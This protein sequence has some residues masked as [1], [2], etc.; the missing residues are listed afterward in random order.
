[1]PH[2][3]PYQ[4]SKRQLAP[5]LLP[6]LPPAQRLFEPFAGSA[7]LSLAALAAGRVERVVLGDSY[8]PLTALWQAVLDDPERLASGYEALWQAQ[9]ANPA[10]HFAAVRQRFAQQAEPAALL[11]LLA[12]CVKN[13]PRWNAAGQFNQTAD[14]RRLGTRPDRQRSQLL[15]AH[16]LLH[17][18]CEVRCGDAAATSA[19][20]G[21]A[22]AVYL[23]PPW[24]G[25]TEGRDRR[26]HMGLA[27]MQLVAL[28]RSLQA[29]RVGWLLSYDGA[30]LDAAGTVL[31]RYG[32]P[33]PADLAAE[34][35]FVAAGRSSQATLSGRAAWTA[36]SLYRW[37]A[38]GGARQ[39][40]A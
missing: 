28:L 16:A 9:L 39:P 23:D 6:W 37:P 17:G 4:G 18:R 24:Q 33:L 11:Y 14:H 32:D 12:R 29:R 13:A 1:M 20:A 25:T 31:R 22:D 21:P 26:Y 38:D 40:I 35:R 15:A 19:D 3:V 5:Q 2:V 27:P 8:A 10:A 30:L 7:A 36:E 34:H